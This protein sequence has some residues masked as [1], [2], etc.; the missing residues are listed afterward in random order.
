M[1]SYMMLAA[2]LAAATT[3]CS[4]ATLPDAPPATEALSPDLAMSLPELRQ[5]VELTPAV[6]RS[7]EADGP[8]RTPEGLAYVVEH[9]DEVPQEYLD[10]MSGNLITRAD[11]DIGF[12]SDAN[13]AFAQYIA[14]S[15]GSS[16]TNHLELKVKYG[17]TQIGMNADVE[18]EACLCAHLF[19]PWGRTSSVTVPVEGNCGHLA[20]AKGTIDA[21]LGFMTPS[22]KWLR[23]AFD[24][25]TSSD[26]DRQP[27]C[28]NNPSD[29]PGGPGDGN[30]ED[31]YLCYWED[32]YDGNGEFLRR[33]DLGCVEL[34]LT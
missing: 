24:K 14:E 2:L 32:Y 28:A 31:W 27:E 3:A 20:E 25:T 4:D 26:H 29:S 5:L 34:D 33:Q 7:P 19:T 17:S 1:K 23:L 9:E 10:A 30:E 18:S 22:I 21:E 6:Y 13:V 16:Y 8:Q 11:L 12:M 15:R